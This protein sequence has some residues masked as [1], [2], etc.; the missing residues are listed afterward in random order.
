[1]NLRKSRIIESDELF[2][3]SDRRELQ[4]M[5][6]SAILNR[7]NTL[8]CP[9]TPVVTLS[10]IALLGEKRTAVVFGNK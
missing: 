10:R 7:P 3:F 2:L 5:I 9:L 8:L 6:Y 1:M 4:E